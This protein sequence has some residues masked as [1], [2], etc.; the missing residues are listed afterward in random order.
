MKYLP[1]W[2]SLETGRSDGNR[3]VFHVRIRKWHPGFWL[4]IYCTLRDQDNGRFASLFYT[5]YLLAKVKL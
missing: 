3:I 1:S 5:L 2:Y 4:E